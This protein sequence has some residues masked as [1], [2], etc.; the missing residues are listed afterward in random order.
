[1]ARVPRI[2][3][4][5]EPTAYHIMSRTALEGFPMD[6]VEKDF[7]VEQVAALSTLFFT[8]VLG[9]CCMGNH[10]HLLVREKNRDR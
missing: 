4:T 6:D 5:G 3:L 8:E 2:M 7:F 1:M 10:F 9:F